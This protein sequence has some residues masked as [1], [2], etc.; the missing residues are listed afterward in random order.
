MQEKDVGNTGEQAFTAVVDQVWGRLEAAGNSPQAI[1]AAYELYGTDDPLIVTEHVIKVHILDGA[2]IEVRMANF[3]GNM[4]AALIS[5]GK[6]RRLVLAARLDV[7]TR[8]YYYLHSLGHI[9]TGH[10]AQ[11]TLP[12]VG[13]GLRYE[14][15]GRNVL[16]SLFQGQEI[17]ADEWALR[18]TDRPQNPG[19]PFITEVR[20]AVVVAT[21]RFKP[22]PSN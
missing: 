2:N 10:P 21:R 20:N 9:A 6:R 3:E 1:T 5:R 17:L 18:V 11:A 8:I 15:V 12:V 14:I 4:E 16:R 19:N 22:A 13:I 7:P